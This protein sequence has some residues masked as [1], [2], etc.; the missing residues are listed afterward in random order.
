MDN[1]GNVNE[2][3][4][5]D[6]SASSMLSG[7][8]RLILSSM[9]E[10]ISVLR[11]HA[12]S[13]EDRL[14]AMVMDNA[15]V[16]RIMTIPGINVYSSCNRRLIIAAQTRS[17][18][19]RISLLLQIRNAC[20][21]MYGMIRAGDAL[22]RKHEDLP[23]RGAVLRSLYDLLTVYLRLNA[24]IPGFLLHL[25]LITVRSDLIQIGPAILNHPPNIG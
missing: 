18:R 23:D 6:N 19:S 10:R 7:S 1:E 13:M 3:Y 12:A 24:Q 14:S 22:S 21:E 2:Q 5:I 15:A 8:D 16:T 4:D 9:L 20:V 25:P 17:I 11:N